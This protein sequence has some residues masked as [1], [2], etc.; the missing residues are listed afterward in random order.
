MVWT[1][2]PL[3]NQILFVLVL[4]LPKVV[5]QEHTGCHALLYFSLFIHKYTLTSKGTVLVEVEPSRWPG[6]ILTTVW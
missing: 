6:L 5:L 3:T 2:I 4:A 1:K